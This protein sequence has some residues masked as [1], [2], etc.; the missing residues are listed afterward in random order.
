M[1]PDF[2]E[3]L[4]KDDIHGYLTALHREADRGD[5]GSL[6]ILLYLAIIDSEV[7]DAVDYSNL[8]IDA[9]D[10]YTV[11]VLWPLLYQA[12]QETNK[13]LGVCDDDRK[14]Q[15]V[16]GE[17]FRT[18]YAF[19]E[20]AYRKAHPDFQPLSKLFGKHEIIMQRAYCDH[21]GKQPMPI[22]R[23]VEP[24]DCVPQ[25]TKDYWRSLYRRSDCSANQQS[26]YNDAISYAQEG[27]PYAMFIVGYLLRHGIRTQHDFPRVT[28][29]QANIDAAFPWLKAA[30]DAGIA[31][32]CW[33]TAAILFIYE[34]DDPANETRGWQYIEKGAAQDDLDCLETLF[35]H[36]EGKDDQKARI[37]LERIAAQR[38]THEYKLKL[39]H[40]L[41]TG[42]G[43]DKDEKRAFELVEYV[44][45]HS[46]CSPY[47]SSCEDS[48]DML[49]RYLND[50][51]GCE[52]DYERACRIR[53]DY[54]DEEE[55]MWELLTK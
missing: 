2:I 49:C 45:K 39:A 55:R 23:E 36:Y 30:A 11:E 54:N 29:L 13:E 52:R 31:E 37:Y 44:W 42:R 7:E 28:I 21:V 14:Y 26:I 8:L 1:T 27:D 47:D 16:L 43:G 25:Q 32:A 46:S 18:A 3:Y 5:V 48:T 10:E 12:I 6:H 41:E 50:G 17:N 35:K 33:E 9:E 24:H 51:I 15:R 40:W 38:S 19:A 4:Q 20:A 22:Y 53:R 34:K